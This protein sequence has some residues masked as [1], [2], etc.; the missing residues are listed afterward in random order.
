MTLF[1]HKTG[2]LMKFSNGILRIEDL[3]PEVYTQWRM[4]RF[5]RLKTG[6]RFIM[7]TFALDG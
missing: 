7:V 2:P 6:L 3:N 1:W 4:T 5:E